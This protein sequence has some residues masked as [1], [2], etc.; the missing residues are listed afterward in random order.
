MNCLD[1][2][3]AFLQVTL[4]RKRGVRRRPWSFTAVLGLSSTDE[5]SYRQ[6]RLSSLLIR[7]SALWTLF[8]SF[9]CQKYVLKRFSLMRLI[10]CGICSTWPLTRCLESNEII[11]EL[12]T[13]N[14]WVVVPAKSTD[15]CTLFMVSFY[16]YRIFSGVYMQRV[17]D[18]LRIR[19][20]PLYM[21]LT[22]NL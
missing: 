21:Q 6:P 17:S 13:C 5:V 10:R 4:W 3:D 19:C 1:A 20:L 9:S 11:F 18:F 12:V 8:L 2:A 16:I 7:Y 14:S 15:P 22:V